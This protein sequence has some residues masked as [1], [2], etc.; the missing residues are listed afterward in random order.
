[1]LVSVVVAS[2]QAGTDAPVKGG[3]PL[4]LLAPVSRDSPLPLA[5]NCGSPVSIEVRG[6]GSEVAKAIP[7]VPELPVPE[8]DMAVSVPTDTKEHFFSSQDITRGVVFGMALL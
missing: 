6:Q 2:R 7:F 3:S 8:T 5:G 1:M 4:P